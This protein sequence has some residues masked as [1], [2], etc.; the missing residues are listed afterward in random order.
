MR[1]LRCSIYI[2]IALA[3]AL[4]LSTGAYAGVV[5][6]DIAEQKA[7]SDTGKVDAKGVKVV[8]GQA[9]VYISSNILESQTVQVKVNGLTEPSYDVYV[10]GTYTREYTVE[11][12]KSGIQLS[13]DGTIAD[14]DMMR[15]LK[16]ALPRLEAEYDR[17]KNTE[18]EANRAWHTIRQAV[19]WTRSALKVESGYRSVSVIIAP[20]GKMLQRMTYPSKMTPEQT[21]QG[22]WR[23]CRNLQDARDRMYDNIKDP[24]IRN[25]AVVALTPATFTANYSIKNG[26]PH[27]DAKVTNDTNLPISGDI[28]MALPKGWKTNAKSLKFDELGSGKSFDVSFDLIPP[29]KDAAAPDSVPI[30]ANVTII[31]GAFEAKMK[32]KTTAAKSN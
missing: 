2:G 15:C 23:A 3:A 6:V 29:T 1:P 30:A 4:F 28:T 25:A 22:L 10:D 16:A 24:E 19:D 11:E 14:P 27:I 18:G 31:Q 13:I 32:M 8:E 7:V 21:T 17:T 12:L 26:K 20:A 9:G 5:T